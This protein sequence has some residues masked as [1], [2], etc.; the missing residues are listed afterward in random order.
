[1]LCSPLGFA[2]SLQLT[3]SRYLPCGEDGAIGEARTAAILAGAPSSDDG[4]WHKC[5]TFRPDTE[6]WNDP[7]TRS[8]LYRDRSGL[9]DPHCPGPARLGLRRRN[10]PDMEPTA[11]RK[12]IRTEWEDRRYEK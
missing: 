5:L 12:T 6:L 3:E 7:V 10:L 4:Q 2:L 8:L 1:M 11:A 9:V